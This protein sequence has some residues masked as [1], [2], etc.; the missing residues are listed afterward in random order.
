MSVTLNI[1]DAWV[2]FIPPSLPNKSTDPKPDLS[3]PNRLTLP[4]TVR[5]PL[6][7]VS[8]PLLLKLS[9]ED[10]RDFPTNTLEPE[11]CI[12]EIPFEFLVSKLEVFISTESIRSGK[13][14]GSLG[15]IV[16]FPDLSCIFP[17]T[18]WFIF[19]LLLVWNFIP[20]SGVSLPPSDL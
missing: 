20:F 6:I 18:N 7:I 17:K 4:N 5:F 1:S 11:V 12:S 9:K 15:I 2:S 10:V 14:T 19:K 16:I 13:F 3:S 8:V